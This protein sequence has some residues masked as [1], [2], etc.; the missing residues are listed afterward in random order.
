MLEKKC[1]HSVL[2]LSLTRLKCI[3]KETS[4]RHTNVFATGPAEFLGGKKNHCNAL[5]NR[6][7]NHVPDWVFFRCNISYNKTRPIVAH[8]VV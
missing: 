7:T 2:V 8:H 4:Y 5:Y 3:M 6:K 1:G